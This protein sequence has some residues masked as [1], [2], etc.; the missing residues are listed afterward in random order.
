MRLP[1]PSKNYFLS[2]N[3]REKNEEETERKAIQLRSHVK[4]EGVGTKV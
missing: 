3:Y 4:G 2:K 1:T